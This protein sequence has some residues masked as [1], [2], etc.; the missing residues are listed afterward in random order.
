[1]R[2]F[3]MADFEKGSNINSLGPEWII[4]KFLINLTIRIYL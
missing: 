3:K 1:M 4:K 2:L